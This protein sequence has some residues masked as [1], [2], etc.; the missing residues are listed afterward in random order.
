MAEH[1]GVQPDA[2][3]A[4]STCAGELGSRASG[5]IS[6][7]PAQIAAQGRACGGGVLGSQFADGPDGLMSHFATVAASMRAKTAPSNYD[8]QRLRYPCGHFHAIGYPPKAW[9]HAL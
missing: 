6:A 7:A 4:V 1:F 5:A 8:A 2:L 9:R 3:R